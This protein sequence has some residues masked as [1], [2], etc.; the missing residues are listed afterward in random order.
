MPDISK[1]MLSQVLRRLEADGLVKRVV[2][3]EVPPKIRYDFTPL[4]T[5]LYEPVSFLRQWAVENAALLQTV[6]ATRSQ[7]N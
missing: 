6:H 4:G 2:F 7:A 5:K 3:R 1:K